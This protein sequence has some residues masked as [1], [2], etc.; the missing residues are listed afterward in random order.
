MKLII[1]IV[2][3]ED[4][5]G[6]VEKLTEN[7]YGVTKL[8]STG[9]FLRAGNTTIFVGVEKEKVDKVI[10]IIKDMCKSRKEIATAPT[11][12]MGNAGLLATY[13]VEV[14]VGGATIFV[15]DVD[16]FEKA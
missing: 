8:A 6:V 10:D 12:I 9:G 11:P 3:D 2:H 5:Q 4:A 15:I 7:G 16:R 1:A 13:P 14:K